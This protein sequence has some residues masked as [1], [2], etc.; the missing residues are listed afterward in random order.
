[1]AA[2]FLGGAAV[3]VLMGAAQV[4]LQVSFASLAQQ[5]VP[6]EVMGRIGGMIAAAASLA[7]W[8]PRVC[9]RTH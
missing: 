7:S 5:R 6:N 8:P 4:I 3:Q 9:S 1:M 2:M